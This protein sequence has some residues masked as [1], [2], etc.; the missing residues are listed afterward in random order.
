[1]LEQHADIFSAPLFKRGREG[2]GHYDIAAGIAFAKEAG[3]AR[4]QAGT[5]ESLQR[6]PQP[7]P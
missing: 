7:A 6:L 1:M 3:I 5:R 2:A 4:E